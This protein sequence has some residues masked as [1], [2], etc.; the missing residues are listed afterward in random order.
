MQRCT[1]DHS[2]LVIDNQNPSASIQNSIFHWKARLHPPKFKLCRPV[3]WKLDATR[4]PCNPGALV[5]DDQAATRV[6]KRAI[7]VL[8]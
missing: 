3:Y 8:R 2:C 6:N 7:E 5:V 4:R 1:Q